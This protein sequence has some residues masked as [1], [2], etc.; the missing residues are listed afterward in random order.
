MKILQTTK[1]YLPSTGG[2]ESVV[3][4]IVEGVS[5]QSETC[6]FTVYSNN[7]IPTLRKSMLKSASVH[8]IKEMTPFIF[9]SQPLNVRY[10]LL[11]SL[12]VDSDIIHHHYPFPNM[13]LALLRHMDLLKK[14]RL[15]ITWHANI[16]T[17]RWS[18][19]SK[20]YDPIVKRLLNIAETIV[21]TSPQLLESSE[22]LKDYKEKVKVIPLSFNPVVC[23]VSVSPKRLVADSVFRILFVGKLRAYKGLEYLIRAIVDLDVEL[24]IVG[25]GETELELQTLVDTLGLRSKVCFRKGISDEAL[26]GIYQSSDLFVLPSISEAEAFG[27]VQLEAMANGL[28]VINT[29]LDSGVPHVSVD[30]LTGLTVAPRDSEELAAAIEKIKSDPALY[31]RFSVNALAR[32]EL[33]TAEKMSASYHEIYKKH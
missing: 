22:F 2:I 7:H 29:R 27:V 4:S 11:R 28:P 13:E 6:K 9:K 25:E 17:T 5:K 3:K 30:G 12:M 16:K 32:A 20:Y 19:I 31:E 21:V 1:Y 14:K 26:A 18:W 33:F 15:I 24:T 23:S 10:Q 8:N